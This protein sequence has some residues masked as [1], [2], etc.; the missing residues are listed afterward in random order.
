[1]E[2]GRNATVHSAEVATRSREGALGYLT[3]KELEPGKY[4]VASS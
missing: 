4:F 1:M 2:F 3:R